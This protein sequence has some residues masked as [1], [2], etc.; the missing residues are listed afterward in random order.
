MKLDLAKSALSEF[1]ASMGGTWY[2]RLASGKRGVG[3][4]FARTTGVIQS[5]IGLNRYPTRWVE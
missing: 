1:P 2:M 3:V 4:V 5:W